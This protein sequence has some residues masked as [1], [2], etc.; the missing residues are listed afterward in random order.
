MG[1][2]GL[3]VSRI[4][5]SSVEYLSIKNQQEPVVIDSLD[6]STL[7]DSTMNSVFL[8][9]PKLIVPFKICLILPKSMS[10]E[11]YGKGTE[12]S[13]YL[14]EI[15]RE[16]FGEDVLV[17]DRSNLTVGKRLLTAKTIGIPFIVVAGKNIIDVKPKFEVFDMYDN[18]TDP[19]L[20]QSSLMSQVELLNYLQIHLNRFKKV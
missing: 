10:K 5:A 7:Y 6:G 4:L 12:F 19:R 1:C 20:I 16:R 11:D 2:Y 13:L 9:W 3:G 15:I 18:D 8:R 17:D 14:A